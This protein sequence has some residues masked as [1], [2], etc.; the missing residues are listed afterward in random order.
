M[1]VNHITIITFKVHKETLPVLFRIQKYPT[2]FVWGI[3]VNRSL[4]YDHA[5]HGARL[6]GD[7]PL[8]VQR[9]L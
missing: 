2:P 4:N 9:S 1:L 3:F 8:D 7:L 6:K 5:I